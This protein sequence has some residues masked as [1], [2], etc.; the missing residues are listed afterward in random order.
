MFVCA[1]PAFL[2]MY[3]MMYPGKWK[4][5]KRIYGVNNR[6]EFKTGQSAE[7]IDGIVSAHNK[8]ATV[9]LTILLVIS[10]GLLFVPGLNLKMISYT[11]LI[12]I[13]LVVFNI[14]FALG[15]SEM[16]KYK[17]VLGIVPE[18]VLYAD[19]KTAGQVHALNRP[20]II[21]ANVV[22]ML[23]VVAA[24]LCDLNIIPVGS[25]IFRGTFLCSGLVFSM[26]LMNFIIL[27]IAF[28]VDNYRNEVISEN[29]DIN[30]NYN[31]AKKHNFSNY[32]ILVS[33]I[34]NLMALAMLFVFLF[35]KAELFS[36]IVVGVYLLVIMGATALFAKN[37]IALNQKYVREEAKLVEDDDDYWLLGMF[38]YNPNDKRVNVE[39][40]VGVGGTINMAHPAGMV[41]TVILGAVIVGSILALIY[42]GMLGATPIQVRYENDTVICH[43]LRDEYKI[44]K[45]GILSLE[46]GNLSELSAMRV[47]GTGMENVAKGIFTVNGENGCK[48][49]LNP[50]AG[51]YIKIVTEKQTYYISGNTA[52]ET[53][54]LYESL[55]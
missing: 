43:Q 25:G 27:P 33:W 45:S 24:L 16:K 30:V 14:P 11:I 23:V 26:V 10:T 51:R 13:G 7:M 34:D 40:R 38:Y 36:L 46:C 39:K 4:N 53:D 17:K 12:Y 5:R 20:A 8:Q 28:M 15:N 1:V 6:P 54:A 22:G 50:K 9:I 31:R 48:L 55:K 52:E 47:A 42:V 29:S 32:M 37:S 19:L 49:Y 2:I 41:I 18:K 21:T 3:F 35:S 44:P